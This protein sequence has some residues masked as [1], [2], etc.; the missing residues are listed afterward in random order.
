MTF[1]CELFRHR[2]IAGKAKIPK[3]LVD[4]DRQ[5]A[6]FGFSN[7]FASQISILFL[8]S[9]FSLYFF[10][11]SFSAANSAKA[12]PAVAR[13]G[14]VLRCPEPDLWGRLPCDFLA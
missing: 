14:S 3:Q 10:R 12:P 6:R 4:P 9:I 7:F 2:P 1:N 5:W 13:T 8:H 11:T